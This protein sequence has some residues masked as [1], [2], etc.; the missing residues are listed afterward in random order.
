M[1]LQPLPGIGD[2]VWHLPA[3]N[4][5]AQQKGPL[6][7]MT[8]ARSLSDQLLQGN[9]AV[10]QVVW[11]ERAPGRHDGMAGFFRLVS[12]IRQLGV[13]EIWVMHGS[14]RYTLACYLAG[15]AKVVSPGRG[16]QKLFTMPSAWLPEEEVRT[17]PILRAKN[18]LGN[19]GIAVGGH[20]G[21]LIADPVMLEKIQEE[22]QSPFIVMGIGS[23]E[24]YKQW[25]EA[26]FSELTRRFLE[27]GYEVVLV[28]GP[29]EA[30]LADEIERKV[31][32]PRVHKAVS[33]PLPLISAFLQKSSG[34]V[35]N[36]TGVLNMA[37]ASG[38]P[39]WGLFG[40]SEP[41]DHAENL[42]VI[43]P[44]SA[45]EG[46]VGITVEQVFAAVTASLEGKS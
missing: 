46:M 35:G 33:Q 43:V 29:S 13:N 12:D 39:T 16:L 30:G 45:E 17:H 15:V 38:T 24:P 5:L 42:K 23:S 11:L 27:Y 2:M 4:A 41:L 44:R 34:Y 21:S 7:V 1:V 8:K 36:D 37:M 14:W 25:G 26:A 3:L 9:P 20:S 18:M 10:D 28:G 6:I 40:G 31:N 22:Y 19:A 32:S